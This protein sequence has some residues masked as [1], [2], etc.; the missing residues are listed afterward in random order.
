M[1][2]A[3]LKE[4]TLPVTPNEVPRRTVPAVL[5]RSAGEHG[6]RIALVI[7]EQSYTYGE[8][9]RRGRRAAGALRELGVAT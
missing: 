6:D 8:L 5:E 3:R 2:I 9:W 4:M 7:G 1:A